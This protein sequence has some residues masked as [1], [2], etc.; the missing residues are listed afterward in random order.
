MMYNCENNFLDNVENRRLSSVLQGKLPWYLSDNK[1][2]LYHILVNKNKP[3][4]TFYGLL[5]PI[6]KKIKNEINEA[7]FYMLSSNPIQ[8]KIIDDSNNIWEENKFL[9]LIYHIDS[10]D[11]YTEI[12]LKEKIP[13][14]QN[15]SIIIDNQLNTSEFNPIKS[16]FSLI[17]KVLFNK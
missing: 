14:T 16:S 7:T 11:G 3:I 10:S 17:L 9:K 5:E 1:Q 8:K 13:H 2:L 4:S 6:Q 12:C 15:R